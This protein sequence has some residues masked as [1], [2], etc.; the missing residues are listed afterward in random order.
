[1]ASPISR[2][3]LLCALA[4]GCAVPAA[5][6]DR[7]SYRPGRALA[8]PH[9]V[10]GP[11]ELSQLQPDL[12]AL[13]ALSL[14]RPNFLQVRPGTYMLRNERP[15][16]RVYINGNFA[17]DVSALSMIRVSDIL[18]IRRL[19]RTEMHLVPSGG[20]GGDEGAIRVTLRR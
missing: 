15:V 7:T 17:G 14:A 10:L 12:T 19:Q 20:L 18:S 6:H 2:L 4:A 3:A 8:S 11:E 16:I 1:M 5:S 13:Q 9:G